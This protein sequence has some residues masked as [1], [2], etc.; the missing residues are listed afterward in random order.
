MRRIL[1]SSRSKS[2]MADMKIVDRASIVLQSLFSH[3]ESALL[4][5][6]TVKQ[7]LFVIPHPQPSAFSKS[8]PES[9]DII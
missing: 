1:S 4:V 3:V 6:F 5:Y 7:H 2:G 9:W 8:V